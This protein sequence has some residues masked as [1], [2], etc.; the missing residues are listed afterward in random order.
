[1][2]AIAAVVCIVGCLLL[3]KELKLLCF[4]DDFA[5]S[6]GFPITLLDMALMAM[7]VIVVIV[8]QQAVG[9]IL[10]IALL[11]IPAAAARF[12]TERLGK[13]FLISGGIG[14]IS[15]FLGAG[16][17][18]LFDD[19]PSGAMIVLVCALMFL[20]SLVFGAARG[21]LVRARTRRQVNRTVSRHHLLRALYELLEGVSDDPALSDGAVQSV[22][23]D[24]LLHKRSWSRRRLL[25]EIRR[26][27]ED[28]LVQ[29]VG[30]R[31]KLTRRG[32]IEAARLTRQ[33]RLWELYLLT[34]AEF[35]TS[36]VDHAADHIEH[37]LEPEI[38]A[39]LETLLER[40][41]MPIPDSPHDLSDSAVFRSSLN[42]GGT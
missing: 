41:T 16:V 1:M 18:A 3:F 23:L 30:D 39:E 26:S 22:Q 25:Q 24:E 7:V 40:E 34:Y 28:E 12:W 27:Q 17:S 8:G 6:R 19:L 37:V 14:A 38:V 36:R 15:G 10:M 4:D 42:Q 9:L 20:F 33:H 2:I 32:K 29:W 21:L 13:M 31:L 35:A 11:I 5:G